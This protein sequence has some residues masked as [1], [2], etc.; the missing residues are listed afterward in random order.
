MPIPNGR[1]ATRLFGNHSFSLFLEIDFKKVGKRRRAC[2]KP[3]GLLHLCLQ[4]YF[5]KTPSA[6]GSNGFFSSFIRANSH[7]FFNG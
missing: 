4:I 3:A 6:R 1:N 2:S 5:D 7:R